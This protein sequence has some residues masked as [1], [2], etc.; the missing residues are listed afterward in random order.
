[1][2]AF[3][4]KYSNKHLLLSRHKDKLSSIWKD[5]LKFDQFTILVYAHVVC[6]GSYGKL[7]ITILSYFFFTLLQCAASFNL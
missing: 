5:K 6:S 1:M 7:F 4:L 2:S 3:S